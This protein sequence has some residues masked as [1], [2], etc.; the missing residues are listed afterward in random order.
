MALT[1]I[2]PTS[3]AY[4]KPVYPPIVEI[5]AE[6]DHDWLFVPELRVA[7]ITYNAAAQDLSRA[8]LYREYGASTKMPWEGDFVSRTPLVRGAWW[9]RI[10]F[11]ADGG[12]WTVFVG[13]LSVDGR[14]IYGSA[15]RSGGQ[16][17]TVYGP[18][19][20]LRK[21]SISEAYWQTHHPDTDAQVVNCIQRLPGVNDWE[22][23]DGTTGNRTFLPTT[24]GDSSTHVYGGTSMWSYREYLQY[25]I[26]RFL[27]SGSGEP[28]WSLGGQDD[29]LDE[30]GDTLKFG[31]SATAA[32]IIRRLIPLERGLDYRIVPT[33][34][35]FEIQVF[36]LCG[37]EFSFAGA[38]LPRNPNLVAIKATQTSDS[39]RTRIEY[40]GDHTYGRIRVFGNRIVVCCSLCVKSTWGAVGPLEPKWDS[41][42]EFAY[43][44]ERG[45]NYDDPSVSDQARRADI[46]RPVYQHF[47]VTDYWDFNNWSAMPTLDDMG[48]LILGASSHY[49]H[50]Q[51]ETL[52]WI[53]LY[54]GWD[55]STNPPT[56]R[57]ATTQDAEL[58]PPLVICGH[59]DPRD[60]FNDD[61]MA[62]SPVDTI[63]IGVAVPKYDWGVLLSA[64][65]NHLLGKNHF[66][67][68]GLTQMAPAWDYED[69]QATIAF[70]AE[71]RLR[72]VVEIPG[73]QECDGTKDLFVKDAEFWYL[74]AGTT[75]DLDTNGQ[76]QCYGNDV[77]S[78]ELRNDRYKLAPVMVAALSRY[79]RERARAWIELKGLFPWSGLVGSILSVIEEGGNTHDIRAPITGVQYSVGPKGDVRTTI[80]AGFAR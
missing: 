16:T 39:I 17:W 65:P 11:P 79:Y 14:D 72:M 70:R 25:I 10:R 27:N 77:S 50:Q 31:E 42:L 38:R 24:E 54:E 36:A 29:L 3:E 6:W 63:G 47:G 61:A 48:N 45:G 75:V 23:V 52:N 46:Y 57:N 26:A 33:A 2:G 51:R 67:D 15:T 37:E 22:H 73:R 49:Q 76:P 60:P 71:E 68:T 53:P 69:L 13:R 9:I 21:L 43:N 35:G 12:L 1:V 64:T 74:A 40:S 62:Y 7:G 41:T 34:D 18:G 55:Y 8:D 58:R 19:Q 78:K 5:K 28:A 80:Q 44:H 4:P 20:I 56:N 30:F 59:L 66:P 32:Q